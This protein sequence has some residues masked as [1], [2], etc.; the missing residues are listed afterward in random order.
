MESVTAP[1]RIYSRRECGLCDEVKTVVDAVAGPRGVPVE[2][3]D[4]D[5]DPELAGRFGLEVP[6]VFVDGRKA[7]KYRVDPARLRALLD[8]RGGTE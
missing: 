4:V 2:V 7:F 1:I 3:V 6:V 8:R 5:G